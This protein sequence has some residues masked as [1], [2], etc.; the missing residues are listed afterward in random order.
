MAR[1]VSALVVVVAVVVLHQLPEHEI[2][3]CRLR[4]WSICLVPAILKQILENHRRRRGFRQHKL[5]SGDA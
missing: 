1:Y 2:S 5:I 3:D 4:E